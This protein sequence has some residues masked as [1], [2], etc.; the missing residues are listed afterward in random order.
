MAETGTKNIHSRQQ[1]GGR[2]EQKK[3]AC[4]RPDL[5]ALDDTRPA[6]PF[7]QKLDDEGLYL[8]ML[9]VIYRAVRDLEP[10]HPQNDQ[11]S[12]RNFLAKEGKFIIRALGITRT[13][14]NPEL[15]NLLDGNVPRQF[16][17]TD[18]Q[19]NS[20]GDDEEDDETEF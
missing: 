6:G 19:N 16:D 2:K 13:I 20:I 12:A 8:L 10:H 9:N 5:F 1:P 18:Y 7:D 11:E 3:S 15:R 14:D 17:I 4:N